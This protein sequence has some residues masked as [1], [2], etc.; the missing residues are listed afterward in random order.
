[1]GHNEIEILNDMRLWS[2][3][4]SRRLGVVESHVMN[5]DDRTF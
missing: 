1:M 3:V 5:L 2:D 4:E